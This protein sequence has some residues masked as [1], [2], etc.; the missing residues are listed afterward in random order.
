MPKAQFVIIQN[1]VTPKA[2]DKTPALGHADIPAHLQRLPANESSKENNRDPLGGDGDLA[3][4]KSDPVAEAISPTSKF[5]HSLP[6][7][8]V[9]DRE[10]DAMD[11]VDDDLAEHTVERVAT[12]RNRELDSDESRDSD[13]GVS[14]DSKRTNKVV[15]DNS[16]SISSQEK[17]RAMVANRFFEDT[18][19]VILLH[20]RRTE[21]QMTFCLTLKASK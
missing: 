5:S 7:E 16:S 14:K 9:L 10:V 21:A 20:N 13:E 11:V 18:S 17:N 19:Y 2:H 15:N 6:V 3:A 12:K 4:M 1:R 8:A